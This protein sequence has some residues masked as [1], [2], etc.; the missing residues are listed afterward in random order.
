MPDVAVSLRAMRCGVVAGLF[1][2][3]SASAAKATW[4]GIYDFEKNGNSYDV[5]TTASGAS[6]D[7]LFANGYDGLGFSSFGSIDLVLDVGTL[8]STGTIQT[9]L[10]LASLGQPGY[11]DL[12]NPGTVRILF[13]NDADYRYL[14]ASH[15]TGIVLDEP[16]DYSAS[17]SDTLGYVV[18]RGSAAVPEPSTLWLLALGLAGLGMRRRA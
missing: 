7:D 1:L 11:G 10:V 17:V 6:L 12:A 16:I 15:L 13:E 9:H 8:S 4:I 5:V 14:H 2:L 3:V 18:H